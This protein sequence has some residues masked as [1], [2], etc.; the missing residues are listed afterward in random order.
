MSTLTTLVAMGTVSSCM[1]RSI[2]IPGLV[3]IV[4]AYAKIYLDDLLGIG[5]AVVIIIM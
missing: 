2:P 5:R 4:F 3:A 1:Y